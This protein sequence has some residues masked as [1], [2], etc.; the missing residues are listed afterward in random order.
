MSFLVEQLSVSHYFYY[1][2][3]KMKWLKFGHTTKYFQINISTMMLI[4]NRHVLPSF[5]NR[6]KF[7]SFTL[8]PYWSVLRIDDILVLIRIRG[9]MPLLKDLRI[10]IKTPTENIF[11]VKF[12]C[13]L[14]FSKIKQFC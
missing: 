3:E 1:R 12:F 5:E 11:F 4:L 10:R 14:L 6:K 13:L 8:L 9:F 7:M 2:R